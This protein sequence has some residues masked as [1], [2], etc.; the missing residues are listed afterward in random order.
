MGSAPEPWGWVMGCTRL[1]LVVVHAGMPGCVTLYRD[2]KRG[3]NVPYP[4]TLC[5]R[6]IPALGF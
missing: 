5:M 6:L 1:S 3:F 2:M 4:L